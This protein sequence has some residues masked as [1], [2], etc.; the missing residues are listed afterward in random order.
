MHK[1]LNQLNVASRCSVICQQYLKVNVFITLLAINTSKNLDDQ[2][3]I[4][5]SDN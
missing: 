1:F 5:E 4:K 3:I 2:K